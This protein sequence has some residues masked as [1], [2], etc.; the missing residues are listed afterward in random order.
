MNVHRPIA[1]FKMPVRPDTPDLLPDGI[2]FGLAEDD[3]HAQPRL[4]ASGIK[5]LHA[6]PV[7]F[8]VS[9]WLVPPEVEPAEEKEAF[10]I[11]TAFHKRILEGKPAFYARYAADLDPADYPDALRTVEQIKAALVEAGAKPKHNVTKPELT[12][13]LLSLVPDAQ[14]WSVMLERHRAETEGREPL[15]ARIITEIEIAAAMI[16]RHPQLSK[17][18]Q[19]GYPEVSLFWTCA[20]T[21]V[22]MKARA[23]YLRLGGIFDLKTI[24]NTKRQPFSTACRQ[25]ISSQHYFIQAPLY[26]E[27]LAAVKALLRQ[28]G[29][30]VVHGP[31]DPNWVLRL[32]DT[33]AEPPFTFVFTQKGRAPVA[34]GL[35]FPSSLVAYGIGQDIIAH[36]KRQFVRLAQQF[37]PDWWIDETPI[38]VIDDTQLPAWIGE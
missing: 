38:E 10:R 9:S 35:D 16:E 19:S 13:H 20:E 18:F 23:D 21:G 12:D 7:D 26:H 14:V 29:L 34:R 1:P 25:A 37:G 4:S 33:P 22:P 6:S 3:Y 5:A 24:T 31:C 2:W 15:S 36:Q 32:A 27:G 8:Y 30:D 17:C 11:G 28:R